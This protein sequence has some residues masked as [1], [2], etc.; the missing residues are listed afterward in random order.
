MSGAQIQPVVVTWG[1]ISPLAP[2]AS[3]TGYFL[4]AEKNNFRDS[5]FINHLGDRVRM[6]YVATLPQRVSG[7]DRLVLLAQHAIEETLAPIPP[8]RRPSRTRVAL[9]LPERFSKVRGTLD[10]SH[11]GSTLVKRLREVFHHLGPDF[12][13]T[14]FP[15][16][17]AGGAYAIEQATQ[18]LQ[19][20]ETEFV[21]VGGVDTAYDWSVLEVLEKSDRI[22]TPENLDGCIPGEG[23]AFLGLVSDPRTVGLPGVAQIAGLG[24]GF[25]PHPFPSEETCLAEGLSSALKLAVAPL[26][27]AKRRSDSWFTDLT[28]ERWKVRDLQIAIA[29]FGD[30]VGINT[31]LETPLRELGDLG[32][33]SLP[34]FCALALEGWAQ[35]YA[36]D[37]VA[38]VLAESDHGERGAAVLGVL[39]TWA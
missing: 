1:L 35:G 20:P 5:P 38:V 33:A 3:Q 18:W 19:G 6:S 25:D 12:E 31:S 8:A 9:A 37:T 15:V 10:L 11:E 4:R 23:A 30:V 13:F 21:L 39:P 16:G 7:V 27:A 32:A 28:H 22:I 26:R 36:K 2:T 14:C 17:H 34:A 29:R 24:T